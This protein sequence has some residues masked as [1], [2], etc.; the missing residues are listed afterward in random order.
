MYYILNNPFII[1]AIICI[2]AIIVSIALIFLIVIKP[3]KTRFDMQ[4]NILYTLIKKN[5]LYNDRL[6]TVINDNEQT[7]QDIVSLL[8]SLETFKEDIRERENNK[9]YPNPQMVSM[10]ETTINEQIG[11]EI[12]LTHNLFIKPRD[13]LNTVVDNTMKT[14]P[15]VDKEYITKKCITMIESLHQDNSTNKNK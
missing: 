4:T 10:I 13:M 2:I 12:T 1:F 15:M 7:K 6:Y 14:Y 8:T 3:I 11:I 5:N 9:I